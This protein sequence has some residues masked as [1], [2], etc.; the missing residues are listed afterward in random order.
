MTFCIENVSYNSRV[1]GL[2]MTLHIQ[3]VVRGI[4]MNLQMI[5][6]R[7][8]IPNSNMDTTCRAAV[9]GEWFPM[10]TIMSLSYSKRGRYGP[11]NTLNV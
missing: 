7:L 6:V 8:I 5:I 3:I 1:R 9:C 2:I 11:R 10:F 4:G